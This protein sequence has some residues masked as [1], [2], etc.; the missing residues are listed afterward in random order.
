MNI[1]CNLTEAKAALEVLTA[2]LAQYQADQGLPAQ[3]ALEQ[4]MSAD[5]EESQREWLSAFCERWDQAQEIADGRDPCPIHR[6]PKDR[7]P[8]DCDHGDSPGEYFPGGRA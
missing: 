1:P 4:L 3:C 7:C 8:D 2:E 5:L 6:Q